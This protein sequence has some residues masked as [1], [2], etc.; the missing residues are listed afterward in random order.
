[1]AQVTI[2]RELLEQ[3]ASEFEHDNDRYMLGRELRKVLDTPRQP[4]GDGLEVVESLH[5]WRATNRFGDTCHFGDAGC[6]RIWAG[7]G[8]KVDRIELKPVPELYDV[9]HSDAAEVS[10]TE[11]KVVAWAHCADATR[12]LCDLGKQRSVPGHYA[13][14]FTIPLCRLS[15]AQR[16]IAELR[17]ECKIHRNSAAGAHN[18]LRA[19]RLET[20]RLAVDWQAAVAERDTLRQQ[21]A[22]LRAQLLAIASAEPRR[23][24]IEWAKAMAA[25]G[26]N[27]AYAKWREAFDQRDRLEGLLRMVR[28]DGW[29]HPLEDHEIAQIDAAL[30]EVNK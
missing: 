21:L 19:N 20:E 5:V 24:T 30:A 2:D 29:Y 22:E 10:A 3:V 14:E 6:A 17:E 16:A 4:E 7:A 12:L 23:H 1:M 25:T 26:N 27:E 15:D 28:Q 13:D 8:G 11:I 9:N 18:Q